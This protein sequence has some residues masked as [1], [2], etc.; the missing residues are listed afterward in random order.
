V[1]T[2]KYNREAAVDF[3]AGSD[4]ET[5]VIALVVMALEYSDV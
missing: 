4:F 3:A 5:T 2:Y 1:W